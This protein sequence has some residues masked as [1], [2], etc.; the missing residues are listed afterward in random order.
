MYYPRA[1]DWM[2]GYCV[3]LGEFECNGERY[4]LG[5]LQHVD[6]PGC[7]WAIVYGNED[8]SYLSGDA[9][10][11]SSEEYGG[12]LKEVFNETNKRWHDYC[13]ERRAGLRLKE[14]L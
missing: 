4:D 3:Y 11:F 9:T 6:D 13:E 10:N 1:K 12:I 7:S 8:G 14:G 5:M 2:W